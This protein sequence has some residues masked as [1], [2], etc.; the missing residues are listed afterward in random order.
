MSFAVGVLLLYNHHCLVHLVAGPVFCCKFIFS[1]NQSSINCQT[2][3]QAAVNM[4]RTVI[5]LHSCML[6][7]LVVSSTSQG[8]QYQSCL[9]LQR[10]K[11]FIHNFQGCHQPQLCITL[12]H[13]QSAQCMSSRLFILLQIC[14][15][16]L[17]HRPDSQPGSELST[18]LL[19]VCFTYF[20]YSDLNQDWSL[21]K[22]LHKQVQ[23]RRIHVLLAVQNTVYTSVQF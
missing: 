16:Q 18:N 7:N 15:H 8:C 5:L 11:Y 4:H 23:Y 21:L 9:G 6:F 3:F 14:S 22:L 2:T 17:G 20:N 13:H 1:L 12:C 19:Q 10:S